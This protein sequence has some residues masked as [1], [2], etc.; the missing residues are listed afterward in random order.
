MGVMG[1]TFN[2]V[3]IGH[4]RAAEEAIEFLRLDGF[5]FIPAAVPPHKADPEILPFEHRWQML[6][7][8]TEGNPR[9]HLSDLEQKLS[10]KSYTVRTLTR[11]G[12]D[13]SSGTELYFLLGLDAF[14]ELDSWWHYDELFGLARM[15]VLRRPGYK[16]KDLEPFLRQKVSG[17]YAWDSEG[18]CFRHPALLPVHYLHVTALDISSSGIRRLL[19]ENRS[20]RYLVSDAVMRYIKKNSL[21]TS[22]GRKAANHHR[23]EES[24]KSWSRKKS[25]L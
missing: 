25:S 8:A 24:N 14:W 20:I 13:F 10:G 23:N 7:L 9:F 15:A 11:L 18:Q 5:W 2:P 1:G 16:E 6:R 22:G 12:E 4:L 3:H 21:Y 17:D 19:K